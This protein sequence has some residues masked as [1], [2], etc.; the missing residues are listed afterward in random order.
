MAAPSKQPLGD[1]L[2]AELRRKIIAGD[3]P[4]G[5]RLPPERDL[6][7][8]YD[9]NRNTLREAIRRLE[10]DGLVTV[11]HG[12]GVTV[13]D[14]RRTGGIALLGAFLEDGA[15]PREKAQMVLDLMLARAQVLEFAVRVAIER[16]DDADR[17][18]IESASAR[19]I[20]AAAAGDA[21]GV[22]LGFGDVVDAVVDAAHSIP[23]RWIANP[24]LAAEREAYRR[25][26]LLWTPQPGLPAYLRA[27]GAAFRARDAKKGEALTRDVFASIDVAVR[28][29]VAQALAPEAAPEPGPTKAQKTPRRKR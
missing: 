15:D 29:L 13:A 12:Q 11:R 14:F 5:S 20:A 19:V 28:G 23:I 24:F 26:P 25:F 3:F 2:F 21:E 6:A 18:R 16:A 10:Q 1:A 17:D 22:A 4:A 8:Q 27:L 7:V 9:T